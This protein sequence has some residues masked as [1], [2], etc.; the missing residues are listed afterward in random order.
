MQVSRIDLNLFTVFDAIYRE[1]GITPASKRLHLSQ[2]AVSHALA[3]LR[4]VLDD[5]LFERRGNEMIPTPRARTLATTIGSSLGSLEQMLQR[6]GKFDPLTSERSFAVAARE[7]Q[8]PTFLPALSDRLRR[9]APL[10]DVASVRID[11]RDLEEDLQS[12]ELDV[13]IDVALPLSADVRRERL[14]A[15]ALMV[16]ARA[17]H[18]VVQGSLSLETYLALEHVL[19]T[20]RRR[21]GGYEDLELGRHGWS[22]RIRARCQQHAA[23]NDLV[24]RSDWLVTMSRGHADLVNRHSTNQVLPFPLEIPPLELFLYW[25]ANVDEDPASRWFRQLMLEVLSQRTLSR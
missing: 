12:G 24:S 17:D 3:R 5:P 11:R 25:H 7:A 9:E 21:G 13:A 22:R 15:D 20:G 6:A 8:E 1:G 14:R 4:E 23:A 10:V 19:V 2:S 16:V 18:P